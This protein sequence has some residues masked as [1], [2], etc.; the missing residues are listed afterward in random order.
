MSYAIDFRQY[1]KSE[2]IDKVTHVGL[3]LS[4]KL[5]I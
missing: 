2:E 1:F 3:F 4:C 5:T